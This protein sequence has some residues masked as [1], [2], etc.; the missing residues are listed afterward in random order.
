VGI[1][2]MKP[3]DLAKVLLEKYKVFTVA[4]D[5]AGVH[6]VRVTPQVYTSTA[7]LDAFVSALKELAA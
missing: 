4:I 1:Q 6:G 3:G 7:E 2:G 5:G